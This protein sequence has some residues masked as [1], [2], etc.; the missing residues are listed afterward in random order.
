M[1][2]ILAIELLSTY[3]AYQF[4]ERDLSPGTASKAIVEQ[5]SNMVP[6]AEEDIYLYPYIELL[7][8]FIHSGEIIEC[9]EQKIGQLK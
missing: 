1:E 2:Y 4:I 8:E 5:L 9:V 3:Y 6:R 7:K